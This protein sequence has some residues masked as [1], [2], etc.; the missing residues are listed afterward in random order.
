[1]IAF[2]RIEI[3]RPLLVPGDELPSR[4]ELERRWAE[5]DRVWLER[6]DWCRDRKPIPD[7]SYMGLVTCRR[8]GCW[9]R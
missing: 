1:M 6:R 3:R 8:C 4:E 9:V 2:G 5:Q 7:R